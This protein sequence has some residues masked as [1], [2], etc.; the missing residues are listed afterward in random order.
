MVTE[1]SKLADLVE[2]GSIPQW[3]RDEIEKTKEQILQ[4]L[5]ES[6]SITLSGPQ[7]EQVTIRL[8]E[9]NT[10]TAAA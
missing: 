3:L 5:R 7:G 2:D 6:G 1:L 9:E 8:K 4:A 10:K